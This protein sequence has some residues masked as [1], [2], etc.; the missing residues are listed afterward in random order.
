MSSLNSVDLFN[1]FPGRIH[2]LKPRVAGSAEF[3][4]DSE[5]Q[6]NRVSW[7]I[8]LQPLGSRENLV[9]HRHRCLLIL[10]SSLKMARTKSGQGFVFAFV[11]FTSAD[12]FFHFRFCP[13]NPSAPFSTGSINIAHVVFPLRKRVRRTEG[14][15]RIYKSTFKIIEPRARKWTLSI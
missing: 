1:L 11:L 8:C 12:R 6:E 3:N 13:H 9:A 2:I 10:R 4:R 7:P 15:Y 5:V 14:Q